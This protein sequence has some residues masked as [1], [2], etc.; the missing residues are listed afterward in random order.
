[1]ALYPDFILPCNN[2]NFISQE[3]PSPGE[4]VTFADPL[5]NLALSKI[6]INPIPFFSMRLESN[7]GPLSL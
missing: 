7:P 1:M 4:E 3:V 5:S 2:G 6:F